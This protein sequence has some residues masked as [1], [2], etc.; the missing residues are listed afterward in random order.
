MQSFSLLW[1]CCDEYW[2]RGSRSCW[3]Q[4]LPCLGTH[5]TQGNTRYAH[6]GVDR[7]P[8]WGGGSRVVLGVVKTRY[9]V[10]DYVSWLMSG[11]ICL[12]PRV[13]MPDWTINSRIAAQIFCAMTW[14]FSPFWAFHALFSPPFFGSYNSHVSFGRH[15]TSSSI[16]SMNKIKP[17]IQPSWEV[18]GVLAKGS[19][20]VWVESFEGK[21]WFTKMNISRYRPH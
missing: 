11:T 4:R 7:R 15:G 5:V 17:I 9:T 16:V 3:R 21:T 13:G 19:S 18:W 1:N 12:G 14:L 6:V 20:G 8:T 2:T 10:L